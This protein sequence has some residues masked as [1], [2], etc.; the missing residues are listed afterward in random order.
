[1][2]LLDDELDIMN[3]SDDV[4]LYTIEPPQGDVEILKL[5]FI[6][7]VAA[8]YNVMLDVVMQFDKDEIKF[9]NIGQVLQILKDNYW[10]YSIRGGLILLIDPTQKLNMIDYHISRTLINENPGYYKLDNFSTF[11]VSLFGC[12]GHPL[13]EHYN[14]MVNEYGNEQL[15]NEYRDRIWKI[16]EHRNIK[17]KRTLY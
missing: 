7:Y 9:I 8:W 17:I 2:S 5:H 14:R 12:Y 4:V 6:N 1:M 15:Y 3:R 11:I 10:K 13:K 16:I